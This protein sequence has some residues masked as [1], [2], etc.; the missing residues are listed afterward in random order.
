MGTTKKQHRAGALVNGLLKK[1][2]EKARIALALGV[3]PRSV[4]RIRLEGA[5][6]RE[7][8]MKRLEALAKKHGVETARGA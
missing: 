5:V 8:R 3:D 7:K 1:G 6:P 4:D 2:V